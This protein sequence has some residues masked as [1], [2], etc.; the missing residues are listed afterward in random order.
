M[1]RDCEL[2]RKIL[3]WFCSLSCTAIHGWLPETTKSQNPAH[4]WS[5]GQ[6]QILSCRK[7]IGRGFV[8]WAVWLPVC[9]QILSYRRKYGCGFVVSVVWLPE[10]IEILSCRGKYWCGFVVLAVW[11]TACLKILSYS[12]KYWRVFVVWVVQPSLVGCLKQLNH[13][14]P[15]IF[16]A[17]VAFRF[18]VYPKKSDVVL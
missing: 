17:L 6:I 5:I 1:V 16:P 2:Y 14:T 18:W 15:A 8:V 13:K 9:F 11:L 12:G 4:F 7:N 10:C 3:T